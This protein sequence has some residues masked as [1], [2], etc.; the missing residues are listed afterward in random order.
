MNFFLESVRYKYRNSGIVCRR[1]FACHLRPI[2]KRLKIVKRL[3][4][5]CC[6]K[7]TQGNKRMRLTSFFFVSQ[8]P[9]EN[10]NESISAPYFLIPIFSVHIER[11][12]ESPTQSEWYT[13]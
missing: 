2:I 4:F 11:L 3:Q 5:Y 1:I 12:Q 8:M 13:A 10:I 6:I 9:Y 7:T